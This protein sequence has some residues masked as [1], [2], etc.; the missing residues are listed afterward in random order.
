MGLTKISSNLERNTSQL[1]P[2]KHI[3]QFVNNQRL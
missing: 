1:P 2:H 3:A